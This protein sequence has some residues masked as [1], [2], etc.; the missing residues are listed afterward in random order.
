[1][2]S[3][4]VKKTHSSDSNSNATEDFWVQRGP[5][6]VFR[7][8]CNAPHSS[9]ITMTEWAAH[10]IWLDGG[11]LARHPWFPE[12]RRNLTN[13]NGKQKSTHQ[14]NLP[15]NCQ[16][17][18]TKRQCRRRKW[19]PS[20]NLEALWYQQTQF[21]YAEIRDQVIEKYLLQSITQSVRH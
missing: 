2:L 15:E 1:M 13:P 14:Y 18:N 20:K 10:L 8:R 6:K 11:H 21:F 17:E 19:F 16:K 3:S 7:N 12:R 5:F 9:E 4:C